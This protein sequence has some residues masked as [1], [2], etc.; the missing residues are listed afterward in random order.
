[1]G[2]QFSAFG[3]VDRCLDAS[4]NG[5]LPDATTLQSLMSTWRVEDVEAARVR[6]RQARRPGGSVGWVEFFGGVR[7]AGAGAVACCARVCIASC[8]TW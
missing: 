5:A 3:R 8:M 7:G 1:M 2:Q 4:F 6:L